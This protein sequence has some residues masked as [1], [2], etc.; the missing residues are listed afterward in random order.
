MTDYIV[1]VGNFNQTFIDTAFNTELYFDGANCGYDDISKNET[2][3]LKARRD[4]WGVQN[5]AGAYRY[6]FSII[7]TFGFLAGSLPLP[8]NIEL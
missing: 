4:S 8:K 7:P 1:K 5:S 3:I 2:K 6:D